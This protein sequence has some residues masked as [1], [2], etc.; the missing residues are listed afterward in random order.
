MGE[1][2]AGREV[3]CCIPHDWARFE[4]RT[5]SALCRCAGET[6]FGS[7]FTTRRTS[8]APWSL[9]ARVSGRWSKSSSPE[10]EAL[11]EAEAEAAVE[12]VAEASVGAEAAVDVEAEVEAE[13]E[14]A[15]ETEAK[16]GAETEAEAESACGG[17][18][19]P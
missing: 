15:V 8:S 7:A 6:S 2:A 1:L 3:M 14:A 11:L 19:R 13:V 5:L 17:M 9:S 10:A 18:R 16:A 4:A 12:E